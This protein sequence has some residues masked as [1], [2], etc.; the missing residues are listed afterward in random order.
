MSAVINSAAMN[1]S[2]LVD[3]RGA[4]VFEL[5]SSTFFLAS[6]F[7]LHSCLILCLSGMFNISFS[8]L[9]VYSALLLCI[10]VVAPSLLLSGTEN[11]VKTSKLRVGAFEWGT[12]TPL[13]ILAVSQGEWPPF[14][15]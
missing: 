11:L 1:M 15:G 13:G 5:I 7:L 6:L 2:F 14:G 12:C 8:S 10:I 4:H 9:L 3:L